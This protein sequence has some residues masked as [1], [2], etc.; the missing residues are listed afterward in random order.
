[1][2]EKEFCTTPT[3]HEY[4][5]T[6]YRHHRHGTSGEDDSSTETK[7][8]P[9]LLDLQERTGVLPS[10][11]ARSLHGFGKQQQASDLS[12]CPNDNRVRPYQ[13]ASTTEDKTAASSGPDRRA[14]R[15]ADSEQPLGSPF[16]AQGP[17][18]RISPP[19]MVIEPYYLGDSVTQISP[20]T[21]VFS[22]RRQLV[23]APLSDADL[24]A[25]ARRSS[26]TTTFSDDD[27]QISYHKVLESSAASWLGEDDA[28]DY[29]GGT[30][31]RYR[32]AARRRPGAV[33]RAAVDPG[34]AQDQVGAADIPDQRR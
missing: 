20:T 13:A 2:L 24:T 12:C 18:G 25:V 33:S 5:F 7:H 29:F 10:G 26:S 19:G 17:A 16:R 31:S 34:D 30:R 28:D 11:L 21:Y 1:M 15:D 23:T 9:Q 3:I 32:S 14:H 6:H 4:A 27:F 8:G 22:R